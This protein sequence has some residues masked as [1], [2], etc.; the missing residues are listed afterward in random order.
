MPLVVPGPVK[1]SALWTT[2]TDPFETARSVHDNYCKADQEL[3]L[4]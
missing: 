3:A 1:R 4:A 2:R